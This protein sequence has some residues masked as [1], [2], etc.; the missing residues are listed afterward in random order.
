MKRRR[1]KKI[2]VCGGGGGMKEKGTG[3]GLLFAYLG[4]VEDDT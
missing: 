2:G 4:V 3:C 1:E